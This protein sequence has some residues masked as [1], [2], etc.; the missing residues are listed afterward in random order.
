[1]APLLDSDKT[2]A[3]APRTRVAENCRRAG[4]VA[5][6]VLDAIFIAGQITAGVIYETVGHTIAAKRRCRVL[7]EPVRQIE[8]APAVIAALPQPEIGLCRGYVAGCAVQFGERA[9]PVDRRC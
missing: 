3:V 1:M 7:R 4:G 9:Q 8:N 2:G 5:L 6:G